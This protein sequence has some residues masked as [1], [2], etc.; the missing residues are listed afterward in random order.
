[1]NM[2]QWSIGTCIGSGK[3]AH[4]VNNHLS[5]DGLIRFRDRIYV[6]DMNKL[7]K[8]IFWE[9]HTKLYS[10]HLGYQNTLIEVKKLYYWTNLKEDVVDFVAR[11]LDYQ[12]VKVECRHPSRIS[13]T[14][15][16]SKIEVGCHFHGFHYRFSEDI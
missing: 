13:T 3:G 10:S 8:I 4:D 16:D 2:L 15:Y 6:L 7:K 1:M 12:H 14:D 9:F 5:V 11:C